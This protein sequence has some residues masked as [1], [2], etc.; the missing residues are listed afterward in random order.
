MILK[1]FYLERGQIPMMIDVAK[2]RVDEIER[3]VR[4]QHPDVRFRGTEP[5][6]PSFP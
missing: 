5:T 2:D 4:V 6:I 3:L 1:Q